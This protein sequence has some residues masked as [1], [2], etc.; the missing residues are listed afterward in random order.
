V[1]DRSTPTAEKISY[2]YQFAVEQIIYDF[3]GVSSLYKAAKLIEEAKRLETKRTRNAV[4]L[5]F[6]VLYFDAIP[7]FRTGVFEVRARAWG[8]C[9][10][11]MADRWC[12]I[13]EVVRVSGRSVIMSE[14]GVTR[15]L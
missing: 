7:I 4:A 3:S 14:K 5:D 10:G 1:G 15:P 8:E 6:S 13:G 9:R 11:M 12:E 2:A